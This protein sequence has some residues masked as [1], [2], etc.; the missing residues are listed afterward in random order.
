M[1]SISDS[2]QHQELCS[3]RDRIQRELRDT[4]PETDSSNCTLCPQRKGK[5]QSQ[6]VLSNQQNYLDFIQYFFLTE[7]DSKEGHYPSL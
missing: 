6:S 7:K 3:N 5:G 4:E 1:F 2:T